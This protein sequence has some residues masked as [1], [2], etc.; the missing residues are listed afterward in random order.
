MFLD[1]AHYRI[2]FWKGVAAGK[3]ELNFT[4]ALFEQFVD[5]NS[6]PNLSRRQK[7]SSAVRWLEKDRNTD[8]WLEKIDA[9]GDGL[10]VSSKI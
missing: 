10:E 5:S 4:T 3:Q 9:L 1:E 8:K 7:N 2:L 6:S